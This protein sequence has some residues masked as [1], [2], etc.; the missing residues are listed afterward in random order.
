MN[1]FS[2]LPFLHGPSSP[3][4]ISLLFPSR[5]I[6]SPLSPPGPGGVA[7][8]PPLPVPAPADPRGGVHLLQ[9]ALRRQRPLS[10]LHGP[11]KLGGEERDPLLFP[12]EPET[13]QGRGPPAAPGR[14]HSGWG[15]LSGRTKTCLS[16]SIVPWKMFHATIS[17]A[18]KSAHRTVELLIPHYSQL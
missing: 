6:F 18:M 12:E 1:I 9:D 17:N 15:L 5:S 4:I 2:T 13:P 3:C 7:F 10:S 16:C 8:P 14:V 11:H